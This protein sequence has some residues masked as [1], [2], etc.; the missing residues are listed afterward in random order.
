MDIFEPFNL[1]RGV[2]APRT[3]PGYEPVMLFVDASDKQ[4]ITFLAFLSTGGSAHC[5]DPVFNKWAHSPGECIVIVSVVV[6]I[7]NFDDG[8]K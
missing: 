7:I 2:S 4:A 8:G 3:P 1:K 5:S 6:M